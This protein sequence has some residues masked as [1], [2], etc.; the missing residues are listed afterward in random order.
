MLRDDR[1]E[2]LEGKAFPGAP[3][4]GNS[5]V[6]KVE[7]SPEWEAGGPRRGDG[8]G[9]LRSSFPATL[10]TGGLTLQFKRSDNG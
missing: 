7:G 9:P 2:F 1:R 3:V 5:D 4:G 6:G 8:Q 10:L